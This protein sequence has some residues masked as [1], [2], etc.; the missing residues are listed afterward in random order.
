MVLVLA[1]CNALT[2][3]TDLTTCPTCEDRPVLDAGSDARAS[4]P[5]AAAPNDASVLPDALPIVDASQE[6][7]ADA[8]PP[9][10][11]HGAVACERVVFVT[12]LSF[13]GNLGGIAGADAQCQSLA[14]AS[15]QPRIQGHSFVAWVSTAATPA[16]SRVVHGT[17]AYV[18]ADGATVASS[19][20]DLTDGNVQS[21]ISNDENGNVR[22]GA[23]AWT[24][25]TS[26]G[27]NY[28]GGDCAAWTAGA[29]GTKGVSGNVGGTGGGWSSGPLDDC[30]NTH[31]LYCV[32]E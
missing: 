23:G 27:A 2:G 3:V 14:A 21:G 13:T 29:N 5:E 12:S 30:N 15:S 11:C 16:T 17:L 31:A 20:D 19:W 24:G 7:D 8:A 6:A 22:N 1:A 28:A 4:L 26:G 25:T 32:E 18:R 10:G 9:I